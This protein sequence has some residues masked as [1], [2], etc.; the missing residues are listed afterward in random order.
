MGMTIEQLNRRALLQGLGAF[1]AIAPIAANAQSIFAGKTVRLVNGYQAGTP[2]DVVGRL[3][4]P[5]LAELLGGAFIIESRPGAGER[6]AAQL[7]ATAQPDGTTLMMMTGAQ[8]IVAATDPGV[9]YDLLRDF[10]YVSMLVEYPFFLAVSAKSKYRT[11]GE[12]LDASRANPGQL[13]YASAGVGTTTH[14]GMELLLRDAGAKMLHIPYTG[15]KAATDVLAGLVDLWY[16]SYSSSQTLRDA[17]EIRILAVTSKDRDPLLRDVPAVSET[18]PGHDVTTW[19]ALCAPA[20]TSDE[21]VER[22]GAATKTIMAESNIRDRCLLL[23]FT[24]HTNTAAEMRARVVADIAK[25]KPL[26]T[27]AR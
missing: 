14:L 3:I 24:P 2:P 25:W 26:E 6:I 10:R 27:L 18:V 7:V 15:G 5:R 12:L 8:T 4:G 17:G 16:V 19:Q 13:S 23:G 21:V 22:L 11:L 9:K 1:A 20:G